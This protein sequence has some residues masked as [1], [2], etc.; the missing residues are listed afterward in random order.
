MITPV[1]VCVCVIHFGCLLVSQC[2]CVRVWHILKWK[3]KMALNKIC[4]SPL[5]LQMKDLS[6]STM[7]TLKGA[8]FLILFILFPPHMYKPAFLHLIFITSKPSE[9]Y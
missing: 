6:Y 1:Y 3:M 5:S 7:T 2:V 9:H 8:I 4:A